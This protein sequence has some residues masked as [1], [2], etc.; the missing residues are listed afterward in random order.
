MLR[1]LNIS[2]KFGNFPAVSDVSLSVKSGQILSL[3]G[4]NGAGKSSTFRM[5][6]GL[7]RPDSG[8]V[9]IQD[10]SAIRKVRREDIGFL[11]EERGLYQDVRIGDIIEYWGR[12]RGMSN[13]DSKSASR[14]WLDKFELSGKRSEKVSALSKGNQ[15]KLQLAC[16][17]IHQPRYLILDEPFSGLDPVNQEIVSTLLRQQCQLGVGILLSAHQLSLVQRISDHILIIKQGQIVSDSAPDN[18]Q[19]QIHPAI[20]AVQIF[21][22][23]DIEPENSGHWDASEVVSANPG[24]LTLRLQVATP[25]EFYSRLSTIAARADVR[26]IDIIKE[27][28]HQRYLSVVKDSPQSSKSSQ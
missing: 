1:V 21:F 2:K 19:A 3:I 14:H 10:S 23:D 11:P 27:D 17:L 28:L 9:L 4:P 8:S 13:A 16:C 24:N 20:K 22:N 18:A 26:D 15:Q 25:S 12:I 6:V 7:L 5:I